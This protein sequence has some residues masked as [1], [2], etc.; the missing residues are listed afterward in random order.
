MPTDSTRSSK[1]GPDNFAADP[2]N[3]FPGIVSVNMLGIHK[4]LQRNAKGFTEIRD[5]SFHPMRK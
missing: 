3:A 4:S 5:S 1:G 2:E